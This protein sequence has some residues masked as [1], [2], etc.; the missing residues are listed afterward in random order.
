MTVF[1]IFVFLGLLFACA[2]VCEAVADWIHTTEKKGYM[3]IVG[4]VYI[5]LIAAP[6]LFLGL[7]LWKRLH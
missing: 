4:I 1:L 5:L 6:T 7:I 3:L 2:S